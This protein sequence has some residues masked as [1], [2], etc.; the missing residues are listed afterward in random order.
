MLT[1]T[2]VTN[3]IQNIFCFPHTGSNEMRC[4]N[5]DSLFP[6]NYPCDGA[7][8]TED[9]NAE[10]GCKQQVYFPKVNKTNNTE[11]KKTARKSLG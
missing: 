11:T 2:V 6:A 5:D 7:R 8:R 3:I 10:G 4:I 1:K 9:S